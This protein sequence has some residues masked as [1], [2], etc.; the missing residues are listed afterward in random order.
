MRI[1]SL[2][3]L[4]VGLLVAACGQ[5]APAPKASPTERAPANPDVRG[6]IVERIDAAGYSYLRLKSPTGE[7]WAAVP[8]AEVTVGDRVTVVSPMPMDGFESKT[9]GRKFERVYFGTLEGQA[10]PRK[11]VEAIEGHAENMRDMRMGHGAAAR[12]QVE[13]SAG[14]VERAPGEAGR[15]VAEVFAQH[16]ELAGKPVSVRAK[17]VKVTEQILGKNW[18]HVQ[19][20]S[21]SAAQ[22]DNDLTVTTSDKVALGDVVLLQGTLQLDRDFGSGYR[23]AVLLEDARI[24]TE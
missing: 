6:E 11:A 10:A 19:D 12:A 2:L 20:G 17:V 7:V 21:G 3:L 8:G 15:T 22:R 5:P 4:C 23:Y 18:L 16:N 24:V 14:D 13:V 9:L 1:F